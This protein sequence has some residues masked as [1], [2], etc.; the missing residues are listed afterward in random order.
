MERL[1]W[2]YAVGSLDP[3]RTDV[4]A[5]RDWAE[6]IAICARPESENAALEGRNQAARQLAQGFPDVFKAWNLK[7]ETFKPILVELIDRKMHSPRMPMLDVPSKRL[8]RDAIYWDLLASCMIL[9]H[10]GMCHSAYY[11]QVRAWYLAGHFACGWIGEVREGQSDA[12]MHGK[13]AVF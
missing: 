9:E 8:L 1:E 2:F 12:L 4:H 10:D 6:A 13:L 3:H 7:V 11:D 5:V